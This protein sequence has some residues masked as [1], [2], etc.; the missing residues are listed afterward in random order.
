MD[1]SDYYFRN[2]CRMCG[3]EALTKTVCL[4]PTPPGNN[5]LKKEELGKEE[6]VYPLDL[7]LCENCNHLQLG[8]TVNPK[9]LYQ[10]NYTYVSATSNQFVN[11]LKVYATEMIDFLV[12]NLVC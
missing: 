8:H 1:V 4:S 7:Y 5:F 11:H 2:C 12:L 3:S 10:N 6:K 9:I